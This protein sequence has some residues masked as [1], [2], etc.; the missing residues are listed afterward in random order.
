VEFQT[1]PAPWPVDEPDPQPDVRAGLEAAGFR[2]LGA[3]VRVLP[4]DAQVAAIAADYTP[5]DGEELLRG[6]RPAQVMAA[7][8]GSAFVRLA[9]FWSGTYAEMT[10]VLPGGGVVTTAI[11]WGVDPAWP[12]VL[13]KRYAATTDSRREQ[14]LWWASSTS[15]RIVRGD[16]TELW[17]AHRAHVADVH[18]ETAHLPAHARLEDAVATYDAAQACRMRAAGRSRLLAAAASLLAGAVLLVVLQVVLRPTLG[19]ALLL[20]VPATVLALAVHQPLWLRLRH[21][22][23]LHPVLRVRPRAAGA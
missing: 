14:V 21:W 9:W 1:A 19:W 8:D 18:P 23:R 12:R 22:R 11:D 6:D 16:A 10:T 3:A 13:R 20:G 7:P 2:L 15:L 5:A 4:T 17:D